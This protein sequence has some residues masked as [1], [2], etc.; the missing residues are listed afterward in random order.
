MA[1]GLTGA[2]YWYWS[3]NKEQAQKQD[4]AVE[5]FG[6]HGEKVAYGDT[7]RF[8]EGVQK[9][10]HFPGVPTTDTNAAGGHAGGAKTP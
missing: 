6:R 9:E 7:S 1:L 3:T 10:G 4:E 2:A 5:K 8:K